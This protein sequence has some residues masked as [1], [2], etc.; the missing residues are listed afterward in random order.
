MQI[1]VIDIF[2]ENYSYRA[3][4]LNLS[5]SVNDILLQHFIG[6]IIP[7]VRYF[8]GCRE[9]RKYTKSNDSFNYQLSQQQNTF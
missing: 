4:M 2:L 7:L 8:M 3:P 5:I 6:H 1:I 9:C